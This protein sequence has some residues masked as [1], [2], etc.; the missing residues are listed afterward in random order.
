MLLKCYFFKILIIIVFNTNATIFVSGLELDNV[1]NEESCSL[2]KNKL[3]STIPLNKLI[4][5]C[6][7]L[8]RIILLETFFKK[9]IKLN[10]FENKQQN[11]EYL[12]ALN[13]DNK[14]YLSPSDIFV[15]NPIKE[16]RKN[17]FIR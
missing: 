5:K 8:E 1:I 14:N 12:E 17:E 11:I 16:K 3:S 7:L 9:Y 4:K 15:I 2:I 13:F 10:P 6:Q